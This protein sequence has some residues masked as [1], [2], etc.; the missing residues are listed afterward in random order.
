M[1]FLRPAWEPRPSGHKPVITC[2]FTFTNRAPREA[3]V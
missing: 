3:W 2:R 1:D